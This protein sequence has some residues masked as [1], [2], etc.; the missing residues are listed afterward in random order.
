MRFHIN[1]HA[2]VVTN[3]SFR[4]QFDG[5]VMFS[6]VDESLFRRI[7]SLLVLEG[8]APAWFGERPCAFWEGPA[9][10]LAYG[11]ST[12][13]SAQLLDDHAAYVHPGPEHW[14]DQVPLFGSPYDQTDNG[15]L[16][17]DRRIDQRV[18][19]MAS[20]SAPSVSENLSR[21]AKL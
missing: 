4:M 14:W 18:K 10:Y 16:I 11:S 15:L 3:P 7:A 12:L 19:D 13:G 20:R 5:L 2:V 17:A 9:T 1:E 6:S 21:S 8:H